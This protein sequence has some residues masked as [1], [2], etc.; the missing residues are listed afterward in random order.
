MVI[1]RVDTV[2]STESGAIA[3]VVDMDVSS[4]GLV[5]AADFQAN[6]ILRINPASADTFRIGRRG[7]GPGEFDGPWAV[8]ATS[9][10]LL[11][12]DRGNGR[13]QHLTDTGTYL[14]SAPVT[15]I[16]LRAFPYITS[17]GEL[18]IGTNGRD[19]CLAILFDGS[20]RVMRRIGVPVV[21]PPAIADF[22]AI[23]AA[24]RSGEIPDDIRNEAL[25]AADS[26]GSVWVVLQSEAEVR[27]YDSQGALSWSLI[28]DEPEMELAR[29]EFFR[30]NR[31]ETNP[32]SFY[33]LR[34][35]RDL[36]VVGDELWLLLDTPSRGSAV[37]LGIGLEGTVQRRVDIAGGGA[38]SS[39][40]VDAERGTLFLF[41]GEDAQL[42]SAKLPEGVVTS[43]VLTSA[44]KLAGG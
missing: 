13:T 24:I 5:Y 12:V 39:M 30:R 22:G 8:R 32:G 2:I 40:A 42:L 7:D 44:V 14:S 27:K 28:V 38:A 9:E 16:V 21:A 1:A 29:D 15:P 23:K 37:I 11:V 35:F 41:T 36:A 26:E 19:S 10:G 33:S 3:Y 17:A 4:S 6:Q 34:Y 18:V 31:A 25:V 20:G 43:G